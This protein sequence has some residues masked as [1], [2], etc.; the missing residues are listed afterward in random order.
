MLHASDGQD[1]AV[2][3]AG[4]PGPAL[5]G[6]VVA[7]QPAVGSLEYVIVVARPPDQ[8]DLEGPLRHASP[9]SDGC[10]AFVQPRRRRR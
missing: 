10:T 4:A 7:D 6:D 1:H 5:A 8:D 9:P 2:A 3:Q